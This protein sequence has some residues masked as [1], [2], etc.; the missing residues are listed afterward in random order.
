MKTAQKNWFEWAIF[1]LGTVVVSGALGYLVY[2]AVSSG[3]KPPIIEIV[4]GSAERLAGH[5][6][7]PVTVFNRG[8]ESA[9][10]VQVEVVLRK[11]GGNDERSRLEIAYV[12]RHSWRHGWVTFGTNPAEAEEIR[13]RPVGYQ[14][15]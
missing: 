10:Q 14:M 5:F 6:A 2:D 15:P 4:L 11:R 7:I 1:A 13:A 12:P 8:D 9:H 3:D